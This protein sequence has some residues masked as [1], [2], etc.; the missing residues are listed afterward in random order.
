M[1]MVVIIAWHFLDQEEQ[2][3]SKKQVIDQTFEVMNTR[4]TS[5]EEYLKNNP[6]AEHRS[7]LTRVKG[8]FFEAQSQNIELRELADVLGLVGEMEMQVYGLKEDDKKIVFNDASVRGLI[9]KI[10]SHS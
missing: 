10:R 2:G 5:M 9:I 1:L 8:R 6:N 4:I 3:K 7:N